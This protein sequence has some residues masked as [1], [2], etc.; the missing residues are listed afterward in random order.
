[1]AKSLTE[2]NRRLRVTKRLA[3]RP[4]GRGPSAVRRR[5]ARPGDRSAR[6]PFRARERRVGVRCKCHIGPWDNQSKAARQCPPGSRRRRESWQ[7]ANAQSVDGSPQDR[8]ATIGS[9]PPFGPDRNPPLSNKVAPI[10]IIAAGIVDIRGCRDP[11]VFRAGRG[12][13]GKP[14]LRLWPSGR[15]RTG[16]RLRSNPSTPRS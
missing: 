5:S 10:A 12:A 15:S 13:R 2:S 11:L 8:V 16:A 4:F 14:D 9:H 1:M 7:C 6:A 3:G